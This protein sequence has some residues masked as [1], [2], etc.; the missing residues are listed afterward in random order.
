MSGVSDP[1]PVLNTILETEL[2]AVFSLNSI[3]AV[4][5]AEQVPVLVG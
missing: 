4:V 2:A 1:V 3:L 5:D